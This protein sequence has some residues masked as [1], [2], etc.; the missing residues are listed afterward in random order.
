M[1]SFSPR[2]ETLKAEDRSSCD[3]WRMAH[4]LPTSWPTNPVSRCRAHLPPIRN[5]WKDTHYYLIDELWDL[6]YNEV[7]YLGP[8]RRDQCE[9]VWVW[10]MLAYTFVLI[11]KK[12]KVMPY[13]QCFTIRTFHFLLLY[14]YTVHMGGQRTSLWDW[15]SP[16]AF[17]ETRGSDSGHQVCMTSTLGAKN[18]WFLKMVLNYTSTVKV[19]FLHMVCLR[20]GEQP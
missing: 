18:P 17:V 8:G 15:F 6:V 12:N 7:N 3:V 2:R 4:R 1:L 16:S 14:V 5:T 19:E 13:I 20:E 11:R 10:H 9:L